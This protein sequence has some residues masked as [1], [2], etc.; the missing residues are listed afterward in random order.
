VALQTSFL[1]QQTVEQ[2]T[3]PPHER[4]TLQVLLPART[5]TY[6]HQVGVGVALSEDDR[7]PPLGERAQGARLGFTSNVSQG[8]G[9]R[10]MVSREV[11]VDTVPGNRCPWQKASIE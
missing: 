5:L 9:H 10:I 8:I 11:P 2:L 3:G 1:D 4:S 6:N 7:G